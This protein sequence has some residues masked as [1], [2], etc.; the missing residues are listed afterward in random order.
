MTTLTALLIFCLWFLILTF[1]TFLMRAW[2]ALDGRKRVN[3]FDTDGKDL[4]GLGHR[5][6]RARN[7]CYENIPVFASIVL[8]A[9]VT[10]KLG[11]T[12]PLAPLVVVARLCQSMIHIAS[13]RPLFVYLRVAAALFQWITYT[14]WIVLLLMA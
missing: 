5:L 8:F 9:S 1:V 6:T 3:T 14:Y 11:L 4:P 13:I 12:D 7:N 10:H 2:L